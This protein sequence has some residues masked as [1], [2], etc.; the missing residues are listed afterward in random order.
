MKR[1]VFVFIIMFLVGCNKSQI[2]LRT[3]N[4]IETTRP[5]DLSFDCEP[6]SV[7]FKDCILTG[8]TPLK[9][10]NLYNNDTEKPYT[11]QIFLTTEQAP[12]LKDSIKKKFYDIMKDNGYLLVGSPD[13][14]FAD[15][16]NERP[17][18][19]VG[20]KII[21]VGQNRILSHDWF[22]SGMY[23]SLQFQSYLKIEWQ[24][25]SVQKREVVFKTTTE[26]CSTLS[27][28]FK[29][30][31]F[32]ME[33]ATYVEGLEGAISQAI[34]NFARNAEFRNLI[35]SS[36]INNESEPKST[37]VFY[38]SKIE[39]YKYPLS[40]QSN[41][42][43]S[44]IVTVTTATGHGSG[45]FISEKGYV[46]TNSHVVGK[47]AI[48]RVKLPTGREYL[49]DVVATDPKR[50]VALLKTENEGMEYLPINERSVNIGDE[51]YAIGSPLDETLSTTL[52]KGIVS[53]FRKEGDLEFIQSDVNVLPGNSG[54]P[55]LDSNG[56][57]VGIC[58][59]GIG[60]GL[61][62]N[63]FIPVREAIDALNVK[64]K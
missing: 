31:G 33:L 21:Q 11:N 61:D 1:V 30:Y 8:S 57:V 24:V 50:D 37:A 2:S 38:I 46:L 63:F 42:I 58:V 54:G 4:L 53:A 23:I 19:I 10:G 32:A 62:L 51:V 36:Q 25:F 56:N 34:E 59:S 6:K 15:F 48:V 26:G 22:W 40:N 39:N 7:E 3:F 20:A 45:F 28:S 47:N 12:L 49:A 9:I 52:S 44:A 29:C 43:R 17:E 35:C 5:L 16:S 27:D 64:F 60:P 13:N 55:L 41:Q 14:L 18:F